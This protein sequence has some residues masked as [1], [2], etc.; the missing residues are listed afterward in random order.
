MV[1]LASC[2]LPIVHFA[3]L[4]GLELA[5]LC[6]VDLRRPSSEVAID[7]RGTA[8]VAVARCHVKA[9]LLVFESWS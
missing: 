6:T 4:L 5:G 3:L 1:C 8:L 2:I 7:A 9:H